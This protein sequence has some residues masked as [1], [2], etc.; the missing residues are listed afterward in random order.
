MLEFV[1]KGEVSGS[2]WKSHYRCDCGTIKLIREDHVRSGKTQSC[3]CKTGSLISESKKTHES[4]NTR[5]Y[6]IWN[7]LIQRCVNKNATSYPRYGGRG[8]TVCD[9]WLDSFVNFLEDMGKSPDGY[10]I[11]RI[12]NNR[13][14]SPDNCRWV[15]PK[16]NSR[17]TRKT[18]FVEWNG[19]SQSR[20]AWAE[21]LGIRIDTIK[22][23]TRRGW[24]ELEAL[25]LVPRTS[26]H[27]NTK[28]LKNR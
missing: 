4:C 27:P 12:D 10:Q 9:R 20:N 26:Q 22:S 16:E 3:G 21:D 13:G 28:L 25:E 17:N 6:H 5:E 14:Y 24:T 23:R 15:T 8:I 7:S 1:K 19:K 11:D 2:H 18:V